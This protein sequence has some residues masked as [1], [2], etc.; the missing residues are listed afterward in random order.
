MLAE[1]LSK[2]ELMT[3]KLKKRGTKNHEPIG[4]NQNLI[5]I[6]LIN[7][8]NAIMKIFLKMKLAN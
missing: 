8:K 5:T 7:N 1:I 4:I 2:N 3:N 6:I